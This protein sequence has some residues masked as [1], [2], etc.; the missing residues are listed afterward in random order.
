MWPCCR[1]SIQTKWALCYCHFGCGHVTSC[2]SCPISSRCQK[3]NHARQIPSYVEP[4]DKTVFAPLQARKLHIG[5]AQVRWQVAFDTRHWR[6]WHH[7]HL[8]GCSDQATRAEIQGAI[9]LGLMEACSCRQSL[10]KRDEPVVAGV[11]IFSVSCACTRPSTEYLVALLHSALCHSRKDFRVRFHILQHEWTSSA[12]ARFPALTYML[13]SHNLL[14]SWR[15]SVPWSCS[16]LIDNGSVQHV[17]DNWAI[18]Q[19]LPCALACVP[20]CMTRAICLHKYAQRVD[21]VKHATHSY[22]AAA[23]RNHLQNQLRSP[24][25]FFVRNEMEPYCPVSELELKP[26][27]LACAWKQVKASSQVSNIKVQHWLLLLLYMSVACMR[28]GA[29][30]SH[31]DFAYLRPEAGLLSRRVGS[32]DTRR[33]VS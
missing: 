11:Q 29:A 19:V 10:S 1:S 24:L 21:C 17:T 4:I 23:S 7:Y 12:G 20:K 22:S 13:Y 15:K 8:H 31:T 5:C 9:L 27:V 33:C 3:E 32:E 6:I 14:A 18:L 26:F 25:R 28:H 30:Q 2:C 16:I